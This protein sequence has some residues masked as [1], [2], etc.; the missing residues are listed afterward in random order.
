MKNSLCFGFLILSFTLSASFAQAAMSGIFMVV[1][2]DIKISN[3]AGKIEAAKIGTKVSEG[4]TVQSGHDSRAKIVMEDKNVFNVSP[5]SK[6]VIEK[7]Q[8][9]GKGKNVELKVEFGKVRAS[10]EQKYDGDKSQFNVKTPTAVAGVRGTDFITS[11]D[12]VNRV[13]SVVTFSGS[14]AVGKLGAGG[15]PV[16]V[17]AG[18]MTQV[19]DGSSAPEAPKTVPATDLNKMNQETTASAK[20]AP[21]SSSTT[22][23]NSN[24]GDRQ[25][26]S[27]ASNSGS[28]SSS[29][30]SAT[31]PSSGTPPSMAV[32]GGDLV[33]S[34]VNSTTKGPAS[35]PTQ[36]ACSGLCAPAPA[37]AANPTAPNPP[38]AFLNS[39]IQNSGQKAH[40]TITI[41]H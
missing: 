39:A 5:D 37:L 16:Y 13:S 25:P 9:D 17:P 3:K 10:V 2:G 8:N 36:P 1:K 24:G 18:K 41:N 35:T 7:Y 6:M 29:S 19:L 30:P 34:P 21:A 12:P 11:F 26:A 20:P 28:G 14:V 4:D 33:S 31:G 40:L 32:D 23:S 27:T 15:A 22:A 38:P